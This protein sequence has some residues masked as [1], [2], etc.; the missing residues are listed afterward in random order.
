GVDSDPDAVVATR[1]LAAEIDP[2]VAVEER[3]RVAPVERLPFTDASFD[4]VLSSAVLHFARD[5]THWWAMVREMW[6]VLALGGL[7]FARLAATTGQRAGLEALGG[8][9]YVMPDGSE[10]YLVDEDFI[11]AATRELG[12]TLADPV[13]TTVVHGRRSMMTWV[14]RKPPA[15]A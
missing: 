3:F 4:V 10:R 6:R 1:R 9:R 2:T 8:R 11:V 14:V 13:K 12:G 7:L 15:T 5:D